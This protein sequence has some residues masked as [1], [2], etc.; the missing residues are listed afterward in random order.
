MDTNHRL[1]QSTDD[2]ATTYKAKNVEL[3]MMRLGTLEVMTDETMNL[4]R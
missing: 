4:G 2:E 3:E 1:R